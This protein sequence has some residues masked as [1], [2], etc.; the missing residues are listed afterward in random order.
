MITTVRWTPNDNSFQVQRRLVGVS[1]DFLKCS[2]PTSCAGIIRALTSFEPIASSSP[3]SALRDRLLQSGAQD[4]SIEL[5][6]GDDELDILVNYR[7]PI[8]TKAADETDVFVEWGGKAGRETRYLVAKSY[9]STRLLSQHRKMERRTRSVSGTE[10]LSGESWMVFPKTT[11]TIIMEMTVD[12]S[13]PA[14]FDRMP[15]LQAM[16]ETQS[17]IGPVKH[18]LASGVPTT[19][20]PVAVQEVASFEAQPTRTPEQTPVQVPAWQAEPTANLEP[21]PRW[22][23]PTELTAQP[24]PE[25]ATEL[26][27]EPAPVP[28]PTVKVE[29]A[30]EPEPAPQPQPAMEPEP[31]PVPVPVPVPEPARVP[32]TELEP[33]TEPETEPATEPEPARVPLTEPEPATEP[34]PEASEQVRQQGATPPPIAP[35]GSKRDGEATPPRS[36]SVQITRPAAPVFLVNKTPRVIPQPARVQGDINPSV[37]NYSIEL[38]MPEIWQCYLD[39]LLSDTSTQGYLTIYALVRADGFI[40]ST[41][42]SG[43]VGDPPLNKCVG[44]LL[45]A[46]AFDEYPNPSGIPSAVSIPILFWL[47]PHQPT[48]TRKRKKGNQL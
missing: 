36:A 37:V 10:G 2:D 23:L 7:A 41:S 19:P 28:E 35:P 18:Q 4:L 39:R 38:L 31:E 11:R 16:L 47:E 17:L 27:P 25:P 9:S 8:G 46:W 44:D 13:A 29:P 21:Q 34:T 1:T 26:E 20:E 12:P 24:E 48:T 30:T 6:I 22:D 15:T 14:L 40:A 3:A 45:N 33:A 32:L 43:D 42:V 5:L